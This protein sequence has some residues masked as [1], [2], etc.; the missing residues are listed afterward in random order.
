MVSKSKNLVK[1]IF[2]ISLVFLAIF[3]IRY[4][5][6]NW[7]REVRFFEK[8]IFS[9]ADF[10]KNITSTYET[11]YI[12]NGPDQL[13]PLAERLPQKPWADEFPWYLEL[14]DLQDRIV[15]AIQVEK[16]RYI[17]FKPYQEGTQYGIGSYQPDKISG[18]LDEN[19]R[20]LNQ[21]SDTLW[22]KVRRCGK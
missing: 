11:V 20:N 2:I 22:L 15:Q 12:Q 21:I 10:L 14:G 17:I 9:S 19:Y 1:F 5:I 8:E 4:S 7:T 13:L 6:K 3:T 16:P 18:Y